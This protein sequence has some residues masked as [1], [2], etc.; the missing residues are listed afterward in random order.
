[1]PNWLGTKNILQ[2]LGYLNQVQRLAKNELRTN[3]QQ[4]FPFPKVQD[5]LAFYQANPSAGKVLLV[6]APG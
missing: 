3:I 6:A 2:V 5:A 1:M 4:R